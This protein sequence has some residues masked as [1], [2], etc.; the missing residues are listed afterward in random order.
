MSIKIMISAT[1]EKELEEAMGALNPVI[2]KRGYR[3]KRK[4]TQS[5]R[6]KFVAYVETRKHVCNKTRNVI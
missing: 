1:E 5:G 3:I 2:L 4:I 6:K